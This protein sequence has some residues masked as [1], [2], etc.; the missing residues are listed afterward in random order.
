MGTE[1]T[2]PAMPPGHLVEIKT[3]ELDGDMR[4]EEGLAVT[5]EPRN[6]SKIIK[7]FPIE[8]RAYIQRFRQEENGKKSAIISYTIENEEQIHNILKENEV[9]GIVFH[10]KLPA[11]A[12]RN[13][14][15]KAQGDEFWPMTRIIDQALE[16]EVKFED[17][18]ALLSKVRSEGTIIIVRPGTDEILGE[19]KCDC[20]NCDGCILHG[21][22]DALAAASKAVVGTSGYLCTGLDVYSA[23][24]PCTM[25][26]M[27]MVHSRVGRL[28]YVQPNP[29][30][31]GIRGQL[32]I[33]CSPQLNHRFRAFR[34]VD[35][36]EG[37]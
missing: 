4:F 12:P 2:A 23:I 24:E 7:A 5:I 17:H 21:A 20:D 30:F 16:P 35:G 34:L 6:A 28:F 25:C 1:A 33:H 8:R 29:D 3:S 19:A 31:G 15:Q 37:Q 36:E 26:A 10:V 14:K 18:R 27:A 22:L 9:E 32:G 13:A 11:W